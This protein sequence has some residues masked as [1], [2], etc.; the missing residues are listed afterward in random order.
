MNLHQFRFVQEAARRNLNL[1]EAAKALHT[2]QPGVSKAIIEL[3]EEL[4]IEIFARHGK[5]LKRITEPGQ[6]VLKSIELILREVGN[7]KRIG[8]QYSAEDSGTLSI[9]TTHT[10]ARY[11]LPEKVAALRTAY[12][13]VNVS[14]HQG[15]PAQVAR[16]LIDEVAEIGIATES[17]SEYSELVTLPCYEWQHMLVLPTDHPLARKERITLEDVAAEPLITYHPSFT[18]RTKI[19]QA[20]AARKLQPRIAL[21]AIDSD[22]I[23]TYV[24]LGLGVGI[25]AEMAVRDVLEDTEK[26]GGLGGLVVRPA[27]YLFG[28]N[29]ARVAFKRSAYLRNFVYTFAELLSDRLDRKLIARA[30]DGHVED[31]EF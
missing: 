14:L 26:N 20:F 16:M 9:A 28:Q 15:A 31:Y 24:R 11:V 13:K 4:G 23:K 25:A 5:R 19:D 21:E 30:M 10:Q 22:V 2:S 12:P 3:E 6:H 7:L 27:G 29:V 18:G 17:L 1:T 8:E